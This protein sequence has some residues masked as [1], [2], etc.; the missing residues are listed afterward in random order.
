MLFD[1]IQRAIRHASPLF[2]VGII[3][4]CGGGLDATLTGVVTHQG[5]PVPSLL[6]NFQSVGGGPMAYAATDEDGA[7]EAFVGSNK[8]IMPGK[9]RLALEATGDS[10]PA[11]YLQVDT[12]G[13][14]Y[15]VKSGDNTFD[16]SL[17]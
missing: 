5:K 14:E 11:K 7:Y 10:I 9:Y 15:E 12:S 1:R 16:I 17:Q 6:I 8:G 13:L 2:L 4:G 3:S